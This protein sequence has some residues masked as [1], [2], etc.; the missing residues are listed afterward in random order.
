MDAAPAVLSWKDFI[1]ECRSLAARKVCSPDLV[2]DVAA[3]LHRL[4]PLDRTVMELFQ[5]MLENPVRPYQT[6]MVFDDATCRIMLV[7]LQHGAEIGLHNH[8]EQY[9]FIYCYQ[10]S[11]FVEAFDECSSTAGTA[12][13]KRQ[14]STSV[15]VGQHVHLTPKKAN[16][17]RLLG[18]STAY[19]LDVFIPPL[20]AVNSGLCRRYGNPHEELGDDLC[21]ARIISHTAAS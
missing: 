14:W 10:G 13:L 11:V 15:T 2:V 19:L 1:V 12:V 17:H 4:D 20:A 6:Y 7:L 9:G 5:H 8:P 3:L 18:E 16:I 21:L